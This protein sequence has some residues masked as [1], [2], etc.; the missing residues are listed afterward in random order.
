MDAGFRVYMRRHLNAIYLEG[1]LRPNRNRLTVLLCQ[2]VGL[3]DGFAVRHMIQKTGT[4]DRIVTI[5]LD[6]QLK[7][8][9]IL[10]LV[11]AVGITPGSL[12]SARRLKALIQQELKPSDIVVIFPQGRI[13][14]VDA[15]TNQFAT[16]YRHFDHPDI[17]TDFIPIALSMEALVHPRPTL[18]MKCGPAAN[19]NEAGQ[20][21]VDT[22]R[23]L[24]SWLIQHG[25]SSDT[26]WPGE[27]LL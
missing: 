8:H 15:L 18:F 25:E 9:P 22:S 5:M 6:S 12:T 2:H 3:F 26:D 27:Q 7:R 1:S 20:A 19:V 10:K 23:S 17:E 4:R 24:R 16:G 13:E 11:G 21:L 14:T